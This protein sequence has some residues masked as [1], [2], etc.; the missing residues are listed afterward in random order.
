MKRS[1]VEVQ[2]AA[3]ISRYGL[4]PPVGAALLALLDALARPEAPTTV[5]APAEGVDVHLADALVALELAEVRSATVLADLGA[6]AGIPGFPLAVALPAARVALVE[7]QA[8][9]CAFLREAAMSAGLTNVEVVCARAEAWAAGI[10][11]CDVVTVRAVAALAVLCEYAAPLLR[12]EGVLVAW[13]GEVDAIELE[14]GAAAAD[15]V[16]L[17]PDP[18]RAV[19]PYPGSERR[20]LHVYRKVA[21][22]PGR[23][24]RRPG[25]ATKR[26]LRRPG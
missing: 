2:V 15:V 23:F 16:G 22:T 9:K 11:A 17:A 21:E 26:P 7:S 6:G 19:V 13:K 3:L 8:R 4:T 25:M 20:T 12:A 10:G 24:P 14:A 1:A 5:R 18:I